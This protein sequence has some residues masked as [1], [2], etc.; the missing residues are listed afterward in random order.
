MVGAID[1]IELTLVRD[2]DDVVRMMQ[3]LGER[4]D[5]LAVDV[6][7]TG[8]NK[9]YDHI[10][11]CQF[12]DG[13][14]GWALDYKDWRG[15]IKQVIEGY[16]RPMVAHNLLYDSG[17]LRADGIT[18]PQLW[19]HD[20]LTMGHLHNPAARMDLK[21][22]ATKH[23]D[24]RARV[25]QGLLEAAKAQNGWT[26]ATVPIDLP[27]YWIYSA[28]D[29][30]LTALLAEKMW[31]LGGGGSK[32]RESYELEL[33][34]I[35]CLR[36]AE[37]NG[38]LVDE[39]YRARAAEFMLREIAWLRPQIPITNPASDAQVIEYLHGLGATWEVYTE[40]GNL[41]CDK[42][43]LAWLY[44]QGFE[45]CK[46]LLAWRQKTRLLGNYL[47]K[48]ARI[49]NG[50]LAAGGVLR[51]NTRPVQAR[52]GRMSVTDPPLQTL[53]RGRVIRDAIIPR[54]GSAFLMADF[55]GMEMRALASFAREDAMLA[56]Y[57]RG[58]DL[59][60]FVASTLYGAAFTKPQRTICK[61][62]GFAKV[63]GAGVE[64]F[65]VTAQV[66]VPE[67][68]EFLAR[69]DGMFPGVQ[70]F[71]DENTKE[72]YERAGG[73]KGMGFVTLIDGRQLPVEADEA[74]KA[75]NYK[76]QGSCAVSVK[77]KI[78]E[79]DAAGLGPYFRLAVHD[80]LLWEVP[81]PLVREARQVVEAVMPDR[82]NF[83]GVI[84]EVESDVVDR[85]GAHYE[86][87]GFEKYVDTHTA[88]WLPALRA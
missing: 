34:V 14:Q 87:D 77:Q 32:Y 42:T 27:A 73:R 23:V 50:G 88:E 60:N 46:P 48:F 74:Y 22:L 61:N 69:Y 47:E 33:A 20:T 68:R 86:D 37:Y 79:L 28:L 84:L 25:G 36:E 30:C 78:V 44:S 6:E 62:A 17:M 56:A 51:A 55:S 72:I 1:H 8:L 24:P 31:T 40:K 26:W 13:A 35:H 29:T 67:A 65:A 16:N 82:R 15:V 7:T 71:M 45:V 75:T 9:G 49:E 64:K 39:E 11:L 4:R 21:G 54:D 58:E 52:T 41:S 12:G 70:R 3:W 53:P 76:I 19:A 83:P 18:L 57:G 85:W 81:I 80:E 63:Y 38:L 5:F 43:V 2:L 66:T 10:R 59:H